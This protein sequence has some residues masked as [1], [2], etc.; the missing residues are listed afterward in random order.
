VGK[1]VAGFFSFTEITDPG[2]HRSYNE[3]HQLD[4]LPE[5]YPIAGV[6]SG[7]RWVLTPGCRTAR[8]ASGRQLDPIHYMTLYLMADPL[9]A[10]L[11][12]FVAIA[13]TLRRAGR[14]HS[15]RRARLSG[16]FDRLDSSAA[17]R[18][19]VSADAV[20]HRPHLGVYVIVESEDAST[21][22]LDRLNGVAGVAGSWAFRAGPHA[23]DTR[24]STGDHRI[25]VCWLDDEPLAVADRL[26]PVLA[27]DWERRQSRPVLAAPFET[28]TP[29]AWDWFD[30]L[31][32]A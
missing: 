8:L 25:T 14:F 12:D 1:V 21:P 4:H 19:L 20:P 27:A 2:S 23:H 30:E 11:E 3:W 26:A 15:A 17:G 13:E 10:T 9:D 6:V 29:W 22:A 31:E 28:I 32:Q 18:V 16:P 7:Q 5:Q 24:F